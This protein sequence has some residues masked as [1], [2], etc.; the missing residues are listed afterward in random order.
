VTALLDADLTVT[1]LTEHHSI[2]WN[3]L[4]SVM[5]QAGH[6]WRLAGGQLLLPL[7]YTIQ[8]VRQA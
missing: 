7:T 5:E 8:A 2:P 4:P 6:E 3:A 1:G